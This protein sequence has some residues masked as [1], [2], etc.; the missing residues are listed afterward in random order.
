MVSALFFDPGIA[1]YPGVITSDNR[2]DNKQIVTIQGA[3]VSPPR[4][5][6]SRFVFSVV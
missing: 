5:W 2:L 3:V 1:D 4:Y 6:W